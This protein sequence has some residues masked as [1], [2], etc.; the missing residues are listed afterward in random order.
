[1]Q[2]GFSCENTLIPYAP[3]YTAPGHT[4]IYTG[5]VPA[6][7]GIVGNEWYDKN[8]GKRM[9]CTGDST[10]STIGSTSTAGKMSPRNL[11][12]T[13]ITDELRLSNNFKSKVIGIALK[14]RG[15]ILP[16]GHT[17]NAS[18]WYDP[19]E[20]LWITSSYYMSQLPEW[21]NKFNQRKWPDVYMGK[22]W[23][24]LLPIS[25]YD[26][27]SADDKGYENSITGESG[28]TFPH[29]LSQIT[30]DKYLAFEYTPFGN[31]YTLDLAKSAIENE[32]LGNNI[33]TDFLTISLS[34]TDYIG[35]SFGPNSVEIEDTYLRLDN[36]ISTFLKFLDERLGK[37][38]YLLFLTADHGVA[39]VPAF[40]REQKTPAGVY[41]DSTLAREIDELISAK[42]NVK[43]TV[44]LVLN[45]QVYL[46][47]DK[48]E[49]EG[50]QP[51]EIKEAVIKYLKKK[52]Y[53]VDAFETEKIAQQTLPHPIKDMLING[54]NPKRSGDIGFIL[55]PQYFSWPPKG[56]THGAWNPY[57]AH[58]PLVW[59]GWNIKQGKTNREIYMTDIAPTVAAKL[60]IQMPSGSVGKVIEEVSGE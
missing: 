48:I 23:N 29:K 12:A 28:V 37:K 15:S 5:S 13:T 44:Q 8:I 31:T 50:K 18:Y 11:W 34:S 32:K 47:I 59:F 9:Y 6:I 55:K 7:H 20:G 14:D 43:N 60:R 45:Y 2:E 49:K 1:M 36:D 25:K 52:S 33:F 4:C 42:F 22:D 54:Y 30:N 56:S 38:N 16:A 3:T 26:L 21:L 53:V 35:H 10:E 57:D 51:Y 40:L 41:N 19:K 39:H 24:T 17:S 46:N 58:I 27:S